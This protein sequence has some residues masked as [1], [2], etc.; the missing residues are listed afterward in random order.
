MRRR[1]TIHDV[2][3]AAGVSVATVSKAVNGRYGVSPDTVQRVLTAVAELGYE[4]SLVASSMRAR[5]TGVIGVLVAGFEPFSAEVLKGVGAALRDSRLDLL[6]YSGSQAASN[7]GWEKRSLSRLSG[8]L[9][10]GVIMV[11]PSVVTVS[12]DVPIVAIDPHTGPADLPTVESDSFTGARHAVAYLVSLGHRRIGFVAGRPDLRSSILREAGYRR[13]LE[14]AGLPFDRTLVGVG[15]YDRDI[16]REAATVLLERTDRPTAVFAANDV[17]ALTVL[18]VAAERGLAVPEDLSVVGFDDIPDASQSTPALTTVRQPMQRLGAEALTM[19][20][21]LMG[22][23]ELAQ[24]H[25]RLPTVLV[26]R[27]TTAAPRPQW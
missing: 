24:T 11:T 6:A 16:A 13:A 5:R 20:L 25:R 4:S 2:A 1:A 18:K 23:A 12:A 26:P 3:S 14:D 10:D 21:E 17:S 27:A 8:T 19:L 22:G 9:V 15:R 7:E